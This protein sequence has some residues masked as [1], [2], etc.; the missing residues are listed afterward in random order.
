[1]SVE[2]TP[3]LML[4]GTAS[5]VGKSVLCAGLARVFARRGLR[6]VPFKAQNIAL[7]AHVCADG[8]EIGRAQAV[9]AVAAGVEATTALNPLLLKATGSECQVIVR[10][11]ALTKEQA[12]AFWA[13]R[14][15]GWQAITDAYAEV[16]ANA[17][18]VLIEGA[19]SPVELNFA[20]RDW[21]NM[22]VAQH[23][24]AAVMIVGD[25]ERGGVFAHL[26]GT[27]DWLSPADRALVRGVVI[28]RLR[29][30]AAGLQPGTARLSAV[31]GVPVWG[32]V[33]HIEG[34]GLPDED[35][36]ALEAH[37]TPARSA[38]APGGLHITVVRLP[39]VSNFDE[40]DELRGRGV[41]LSMV[42][43]CDA[44]LQVD[45]ARHWLVLPGTKATRAD[46]E[47]LRSSGWADA[48]GQHLARG[49]RVLGIC[50]GYQMLGAVVRD[51]DGVEGA[52]GD[53]PG[54]GLLPVETTFEADK[55]TRR[56]DLEGVPEAYQIQHGRVRVQPAA[57]GW[58]ALVAREQ[59]GGELRDGWACG[60]VWG[61]SLH[62]VAALVLA[63][64]AALEAGEAWSPDA[65]QAAA[66]PLSAALDIWADHLEAALDIASIERAFKGP[67]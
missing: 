18:L 12:S 22:R 40:L 35:G 41:T 39:H 27:L 42:S 14:A 60:R 66:P 16:A 9:Q 62:G 4:Q 58:P 56:F 29:G 3:A 67:R 51:P 6:V 59:A 23:A 38:V 64:A 30:D 36:L 7:N 49:G 57:A 45:A 53:A 34:L 50:G 44:L 5:G 20:E 13:D 19:G 65:A 15:L 46:L 55:Q 61:T 21:T 26:R 32:V 47:W 28:N 31:T 52:P 24:H 43:T 63:R 11:R 25:I 54:L 2:R 37:A 48:L 10:G 17:D 1:M 8:G 33:P